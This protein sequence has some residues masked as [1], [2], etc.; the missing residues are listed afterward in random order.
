MPN[1]PLEALCGIGHGSVGRYRARRGDGESD[2]GGSYDKR[3]NAPLH[4][5]RA[6]GR[7]RGPS[8]CC[9]AVHAPN[10]TRPV[11]PRQE[12]VRL[13]RTPP[14]HR[15]SRPLRGV[16]RTDKTS[17][18]I[19]LYRCVD[20]ASGVVRAP[21]RASPDQRHGGKQMKRVVV[22]MLLCGRDPRLGQLA[23]TRHQASTSRP[24]SARCSSSSTSSVPLTIWRRCA[25]SRT[26]SA[27]PA[28]TRRNMATVPFFSHTSPN[29]RTPAQRAIAA[30]YTTRGF[31]S[32]TDR[33]GD[34]LGLRRVRARPRRSCAAG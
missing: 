6:T 33:G 21:P 29:G 14:A 3:R 16:A 30:G 28:S 11:R 22:A 2:D 13:Q 4:D 8:P 25:L 9:R 31:R 18:S 27:Q 12:G 5:L 20:S 19:S 26:C 34:R 23:G 15:S 1:R 10:P 7:E 24:P 17:G 32:W